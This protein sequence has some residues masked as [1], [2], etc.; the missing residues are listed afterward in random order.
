MDYIFFFHNIHCQSHT[1]DKVYRPHFRSFRH[2]FS[3]QEKYLGI[4]FYV[5]N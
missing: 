4:I 5:T 1:F 2:Y 3:W